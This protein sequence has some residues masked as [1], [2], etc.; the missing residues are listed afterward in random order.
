MSSLG[1][2]MRESAPNFPY[3]PHV[4]YSVDALASDEEY[5]FLQATRTFRYPCGLEVTEDYLMNLI[6]GALQALTFV[7]EAHHTHTQEPMN[8]GFQ[9][10]MIV[11]NSEVRTTF[12]CYHP[13]SVE[14]DTCDFL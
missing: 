1:E 11:T 14:F 4:R 5:E 13:V 7:H 9:E 10:E 2:T 3:N 8:W 12:T 6:S